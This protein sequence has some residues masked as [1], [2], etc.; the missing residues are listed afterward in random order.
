MDGLI[1]LDAL[2]YLEVEREIKRTVGVGKHQKR[3]FELSRHF[4]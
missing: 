1:D 4:W 3:V 2:I